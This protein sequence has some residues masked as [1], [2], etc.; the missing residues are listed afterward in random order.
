MRDSYSQ[1]SISLGNSNAQTYSYLDFVV[2]FQSM[3]INDE[4][5]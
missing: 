3:T 5:V 2:S 4:S 1:L